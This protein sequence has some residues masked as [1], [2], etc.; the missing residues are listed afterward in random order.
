MKVHTT[1]PTPARSSAPDRGGADRPSGFREALE[2]SL[3]RV[4]EGDR[5]LA[6]IVDRG[7]ASAPIAPTELLRLQAAVYRTTQELD[8]AG[9]LVDKAT[10]AVKT[11]LQS[12]S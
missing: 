2:A 7:H 4:A 10:Q 5:A 1:P 6:E 8:L 12:Q 11:T 9:R 3:H